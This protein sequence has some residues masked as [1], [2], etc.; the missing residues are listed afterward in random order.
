MLRATT[1]ALALSICAGAA[2]AI[3]IVSAFPSLGFDQPVDLQNAGDGT[4]RLFVVERQGTIW[5][6]DNHPAV[7]TKALFLDISA[8]VDSDASEEGLLGL[9]FHPQYPDSP[10]VYVNYTT[11]IPATHT[12][13]SRF[14]VTS[15]PDSADAASELSIIEIPKPASNHN[16]GQVAFGGDGYLYLGTGDGGGAGD[17]L[18]SGQDLTTLLGAMLRIDVDDPQA[19]LNYGIPVDNPFVGNMSGYREEIWAYGFRNPWRFSIDPATQK[20]WVGDVGQSL[21]EEVDTVVVGANYGWNVLEGE[22]CY[23][24]Q[25]CNSTG[26]TLPVWTYAHGCCS[27]SITG[28]Y[29]YR[30]ALIVDWIGKYVF[31][32]YQTGEIWTIELADTGT[33]NTP[34]ANTSHYI[35]SFGVDENQNL[36]F[37]SYLQGR[38]YRFMPTATGVSGEPAAPSRGQLE[39]NFPNPFNPGTTIE[40]TVAEPALVEVLIYDVR[41]ARVRSLV[42]TRMPS[43]RHRT[44]WDGRDAA[45]RR[46]ASGVYYAAFRIDGRTADTRRM[47]LLK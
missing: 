14:T 30:G 42:S 18:G 24:A 35:S 28:G 23:Q 37:C 47:V 7:T 21:Y 22:E 15:N 32:D 43:G 16:A 31:G 9:T 36:F 8:L 45:G 40:Y 5:V 27:K 1:L 41:G 17:P 44:E 26:M 2:S 12:Q 20:V 34:I 13:I 29:V 46:L 38:I 33:V 11:N 39:R 6:F 4:N 3:D 10:Y 19:P 25:S